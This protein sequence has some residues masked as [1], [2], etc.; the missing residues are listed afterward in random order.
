MQP[1]PSS[2]LPGRCWAQMG[3]FEQSAA[4]VAAP[5]EVCIH[6]PRLPDETA[7]RALGVG[8]PV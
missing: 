3:S 1:A 7:E 5:V 2:A 4:V 6:V 8:A